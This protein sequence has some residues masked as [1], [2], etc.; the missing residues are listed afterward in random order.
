MS[1]SN[2]LAITDVDLKGKRVLIRVDFNVPLNSSKNIT[3]NQRIV[4]ALPTIKYAGDHGA[5]AVILMSHLGRPDGKVSEKYSLKPIVPELEKLLGK[6]VVFTD[7]CVGPK[8]E[9]AVSKA[10]DG[11]VILLENLRFHAEE[12]GSS[13]DVEGKKVK[14]DKEKVAEFRKGLTALG[15]VYINDAFGTAHRAHSSMVGVELPQKASGFLMKKELD[16]FAQALES[17][18]RPFLAILGGAKVSDKI[19]LIDNLLTKVDSLIICGGMAYTFKKTLENVKIGNSLFDEAGSKTVGDLI[20]KAKK[21]GVKIVLP[22]DYVTAD[23]FDKDAKTGYATDEE[24]IPDGWMGLDVGEKSVK[25]FESTISEAKTI[26]WNGPAGVF[27][28][29]AFAKGTKAMLDTAVDAAQNGKI[30]IIGGGDTATV[31]AKYG[32]E[33]KLSHVSTGGGASLELLEGKD[34]P[35]VLALSS[36]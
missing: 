33:D 31:A 1:L 2:K 18:K 13:K 21:N 5:K 19:Q 16:Y 34:L 30:V 8:V 9:E 7:D 20:E 6:K 3:N 36:K 14:A 11:Q 10:S 28:F 35:G 27:E 17:P 29:D 22:C 12:E 32:V 4:G 26:L 24:G 23:K 15:D 25:L